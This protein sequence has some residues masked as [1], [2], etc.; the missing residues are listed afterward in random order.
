[1]IK[2]IEVTKSAIIIFVIA[3]CF[4]FYEFVMQVA[5]GVMAQTLMHDLLINATTLGVVS[6]CFYYSYS[7]M[8]FPGGILIDRFGVRIVLFVAS[9]VCSIGVLLFGLATNEYVAAIARFIMG[10]GSSIAFISV[11]HISA[12]W[13]PIK[14]FALLTGITEMMGSLGAMGGSAPLTAM[15]NNFGWRK[16]I[17]FFAIGGMVLSLLIVFFVRNHPRHESDKKSFEYE[18]SALK[19]IKI[20][21]SNLQTWYIGIY[22]FCI[23]APVLAFSALWGVSFLKA[24]CQINDV[25]AA[26]A[27][28]FTW[29]GVA[30]ASPF[31]GWLSDRIKKRCIFMF[32]PAFVGALAISIVIF[33]P[34]IPEYTLY[35][36][37][38]LIGFAS[39]GQTISFATIKD[40]NRYSMLGTANG[41]NNMIVVLGGIFFQPLI[42]KFLDMNWHGAL[43]NGV[44]IY[45]L[46][47]YKTAFIVLPI[48]YFIAFLVGIF[49][50]KETNCKEANL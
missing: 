48:C 13:F 31:L 46:H 9:G 3:S 20:V 39:S 11:L 47:N 36:L 32:I 28:S 19:N 35:L 1:M 21:F 41:L 6:S 4:Y 17:L 5:P 24:S 40:N 18:K 29:L 33:A 37:M 27:I 42:G 16:T 49:L 8:Q 26:K 22:S 45:D 12:A 23:W 50:I 7:F 25:A 2:K 30:L 34:N 43:L 38:F 15:F 10:C 44:R 14:Y